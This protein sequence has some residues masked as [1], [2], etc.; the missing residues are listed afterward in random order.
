MEAQSITKKQMK[1]MVKYFNLNNDFLD[2]AIYKIMKKLKKIERR[3]K[4]GN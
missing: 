1:E 3:I 4:N 2:E